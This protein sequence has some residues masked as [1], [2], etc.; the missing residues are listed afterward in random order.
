MIV[1]VTVT[2]EL[3]ETVICTVENLLQY[4]DILYTT[5]IIQ[6]MDFRVSWLVMTLSLLLLLSAIRSDLY[7]YDILNWMHKIVRILIIIKILSTQLHIH[8][9]IPVLTYLNTYLFAYLSILEFSVGDRSTM[10]DIFTI[11]VFTHIHIHL[12]SFYLFTS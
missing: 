3:I 11:Y 2:I 5:V 10:G 12:F 7:Q 8:S 6:H 4:L 9:F 1:M